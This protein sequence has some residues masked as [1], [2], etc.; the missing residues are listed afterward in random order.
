M[1]KYISNLIQPKIS[2]ALKVIHLKFLK[3]KFALGGEVYV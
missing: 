2:I 3:F 1:E